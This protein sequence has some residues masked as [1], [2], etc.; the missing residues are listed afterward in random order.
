M[1]APCDLRGAKAPNFQCVLFKLVSV[2]LFVLDVLGRG[3]QELNWWFDALK[4]E[5][6]SQKSVPCATWL[7]L[8]GSCRTSTGMG[9][10][11]SWRGRLCWRRLGV[12]SSYFLEE[13]DHS[14]KDHGNYQTIFGLR[15]CEAIES[16]APK[17]KNCR[18]SRQ[19]MLDLAPGWMWVYVMSSFLALILPRNPKARRLSSRRI[20]PNQIGRRL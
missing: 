15:S 18:A 17:A 16:M 12:S 10:S 20:Y 14:E 1:V 7:V 11:S 4:R 9:I 2:N 19:R 8:E 3:D 5:E 6:R 13:T